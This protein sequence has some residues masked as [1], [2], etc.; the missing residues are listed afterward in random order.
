MRT[1]RRT[2]VAPVAPPAKISGVSIMPSPGGSGNR[3]G[4]IGLGPCERQPK[5]RQSDWDRRWCGGEFA[6]R[7]EARC[8]AVSV[9]ARPL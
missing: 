1:A 5:L 2:T 8:S 6:G 3:I 7:R 9:F 4:L